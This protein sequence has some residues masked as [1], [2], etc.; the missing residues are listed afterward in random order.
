MLFRCLFLSVIL[1]GLPAAEGGVL[2]QFDF[3]FGTVDVELFEQDKPKTVQNFLAYANS[4]FWN[5]TIMHR[6]VQNFVI[7]GGSYW[8]SPTG[9]V[10]I[11]TLPPV[12]NEY[13]VGR[14]FSNVFGTIAM[15]R[16]GG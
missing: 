5:P 4:G 10:G 3:N 14:T 8:M 9:V 16:V 2:A 13:S 6:W 1:L 7:Q 12:T 15:A 11:P